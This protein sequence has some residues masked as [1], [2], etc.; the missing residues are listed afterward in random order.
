MTNADEVRKD[1]ADFRVQYEKQQ[2]ENKA[3]LSALTKEV[4]RLAAEVLGL[5]RA[6]AGGGQGKS[7]LERV[8]RNEVYV[9]LLAGS[10]GLLVLVILLIRFFLDGLSK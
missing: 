10:G 5:T 7:I 1:L 2:S 8:T 9:K 4:G 3:N 6:I